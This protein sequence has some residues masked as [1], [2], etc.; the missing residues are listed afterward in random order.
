MMPGFKKVDQIEKEIDGTKATFDHYI[1]D[2]GE[3]HPKSKGKE[4]YANLYL[5]VA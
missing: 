1:G 3:R 5:K 2:L 4:I